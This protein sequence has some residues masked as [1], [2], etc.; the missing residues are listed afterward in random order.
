MEWIYL[1]VIIIVAFV[2]AGNLVYF[3]IFPLIRISEWLLFAFRITNY[4]HQEFKGRKPFIN[5][6]DNSEP[7]PI[8]GVN[9]I[10]YISQI[11]H[12][13]RS[14]YDCEYEKRLNNLCH[15]FFIYSDYWIGLYA[16]VL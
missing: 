15:V 12:Y 4:C 9:R 8:E 5:L 2:I 14:T 6:K 1:S 16:N 11:K 13:T 3:L 10:S 7:C